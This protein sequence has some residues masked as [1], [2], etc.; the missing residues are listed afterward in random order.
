[1]GLKRLLI[2]FVRFMIYILWKY[3]NVF[4]V[5]YF[6]DVIVYLKDSKEYDN[7]VWL[8][9]IKFMEVGLTLKIK[10]CKFDTI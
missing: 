10:K 2:E 8:V 6:D 1:M 4:V 9:M 3:F 5:V 7:Y